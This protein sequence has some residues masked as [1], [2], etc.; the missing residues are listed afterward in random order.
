MYPHGRSLV[1]NLAGKPFVLLG[2]NSDRDRD[3]LKITLM[4][5]QITWRSWWDESIDG[6]IHTAWQVTERP[7]IYLLDAQ[8]TIRH[9]NIQPEN[10]T[11]A[12]NALLA[13][14]SKRKK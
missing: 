14:E 6:R 11:A 5:E 8:G 2:I 12:I 4:K 13:E 1:G 7:A 10:I 3:E 9:K